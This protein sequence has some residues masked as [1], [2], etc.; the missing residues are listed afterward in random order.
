MLTE[1]EMLQEKAKLKRQFGRKCILGFSLKILK[2]A[3]FVL[4]EGH[5][6]VQKVGGR[7]G[8]LLTG[9]TPQNY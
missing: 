1:E 2:L 8:E 9:T 7:Q 5:L 3:C 4:G 6:Q